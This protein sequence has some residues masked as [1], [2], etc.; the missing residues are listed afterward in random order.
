[1]TT[2]GFV[3]HVGFRDLVEVLPGLLIG[4]WLGWKAR[5]RR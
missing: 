4:L 1:M 3:F 2:H 5:G